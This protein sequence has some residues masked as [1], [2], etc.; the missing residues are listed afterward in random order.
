MPNKYWEKIKCWE[1][2]MRVKEAGLHQNHIVI[3]DFNTTLHQ[4]EEKEVLL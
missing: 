2:L 1:S 3:G 4:R